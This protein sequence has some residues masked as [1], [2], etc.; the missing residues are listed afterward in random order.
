MA[1]ATALA[2]ENNTTIVQNMLK[3]GKVLVGILIFLMGIQLD[4]CAPLPYGANAM[5]YIRSSQGLYH[6]AL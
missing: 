2:R 5:P 6:S 1:A 3:C 4:A